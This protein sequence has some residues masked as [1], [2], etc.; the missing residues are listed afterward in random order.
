MVHAKVLAS[1]PKELANKYDLSSTIQHKG[2]R[3]R[4]RE[5]GVAGF[6]RENLPDAFGVATGELFSFADD[7]VSPQCD[8]IVYDRL[9]TPILGRSDPVQQVPI[10]GTYAVIEVRSILDTGALDA[11]A[12][13]FDA[14]RSMWRMA[15]PSIDHGPD[16]PAF[17]LF[18]YR[19]HTTSTSCTD[20]LRRNMDEDTSIVALDDGCS[21][22]VGSQNDPSARPAWLDMLP[23]EFG[24]YSALAFFLFGVLEACRAPL[25]PL[26]FGTIFL[27]G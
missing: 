22:W 25:M 12:R 19:M 15:Y 5:D 27:R 18:G 23:P 2:E 17:F 24:M 26:D 20:M 6:L 9:H 3:G 4:Q 8:L 1:L 11:A 7:H 21:V 16:G 10:E 14:I 13:K